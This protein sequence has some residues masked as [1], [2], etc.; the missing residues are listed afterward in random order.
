MWLEC[1][2]QSAQTKYGRNSYLSMLEILDAVI[3]GRYIHYFIGLFFFSF[4]YDIVKFYWFLV[5][6]G[7]LSCRSLNVCE[8]T[9]VKK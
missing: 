1:T 3:V 5:L 6:Y 4:Q 9:V 2:R 8:M 7:F